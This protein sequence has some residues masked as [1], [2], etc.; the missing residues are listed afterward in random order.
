M[1]A[2]QVAERSAV[3]ALEDAVAP[4]TGEAFKLLATAP[5]GVAKLRELILSLAVRG[6][7]VGQISADVPASKLSEQIAAA[8]KAQPSVCRTRRRNGRPQPPEEPFEIPGSWAWVGLADVTY[9]HGQQTPSASFTYIDV[10]SIDSVRGCIKSKLPTVAALEAPSRAR[11]LVEEGTVIYSTVRPYLKNIAIVS[12]SYD[13]TPIASTAFAVLHPNEGLLSKYLY[14]YLRSA[15]FTSFV[16]SRMIGVAYPAIN[17]ASFF[18]GML[19]LPPLAE[20]RRIVARVEELMGLCD[21]LEAHGR[22]QD[23]QHAGL[24]A[25]PVRRPRRQHLARGTGRKLATHRPPLRPATRPPRSRRRA[26]T[27]L[28]ATRRPR[29]ARAARPGRRTRQRIAPTHLRPERPTH[30]RGQG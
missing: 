9:E 28:P 27:N 17:D 24:V 16:A 29:P 11:K 1:N 14:Y 4:V 8:R 23:E 30:R 20:Q 12:E 3:Y 5:Q 2:Q 7:L 18:E 25:D 10:A 21:E 22:L 19:P 6:R 15:E 13:P 26:G